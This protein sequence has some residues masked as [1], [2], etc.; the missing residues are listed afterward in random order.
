MINVAV[1]TVVRIRFGFHWMRR[2]LIGTLLLSPASINRAKGKQSNKFKVYRFSDDQLT[3]QTRIEERVAVVWLA[4]VK[5]EDLSE[6]MGVRERSLE[7]QG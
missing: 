4:V 6:A 3:V 7:D 1:P 2:H 5:Q